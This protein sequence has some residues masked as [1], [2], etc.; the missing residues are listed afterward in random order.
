MRTAIVLAVCFAL[1]GCGSLAKK[2]ALV[3]IGDNTN[4]VRLKMGEPG[5]RQ[6]RGSQEA[7]QYCKTGAGLG[8]H[9][10]RVIWFHSG[11]VTG[12]N[13]YKGTRP[14]SSCTADFRE[15]RWEDAPDATLEIR[16]R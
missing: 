11:L 12:F 4:D 5:D 15:I 16:S 10:Y 3:D 1:A 2:A 13:S 6:A 8:Y 7:W 14:A 9:D